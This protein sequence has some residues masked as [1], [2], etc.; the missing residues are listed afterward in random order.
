MFVV[1]HSGNISE[2]LGKH[3]EGSKLQ[4]RKETSSLQAFKLLQ[5]VV[6][7]A[8]Q[9]GSAMKC[10]LH[11]NGASWKATTQGRELSLMLWNGAVLR[12]VLRT[13]SRRDNKRQN[14]NWRTLSRP[15]DYIAFSLHN[16]PVLNAYRD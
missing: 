12:R 7:R 6:S 4:R 10:E 14:W 9:W 5:S 1:S 8:D 15:R 13:T 3:R 16:R 2:F 11:D